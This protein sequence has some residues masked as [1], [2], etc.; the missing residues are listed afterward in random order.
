MATDMT[1]TFRPCE[2]HLA[3]TPA[4]FPSGHQDA[5]LVEI[6]S[7]SPRGSESLAYTVVPRTSARVPH[8]SG[9]GPHSEQSQQ[10]RGNSR[11]W[12]RLGC[13]TTRANDAQC[14]GQFI[15]TTPLIHFFRN[16]RHILLHS[17]NSLRG[18]SCTSAHGHFYH[19]LSASYIS[20]DFGKQSASRQSNKSRSDSLTLSFVGFGCS[21][22]PTVH[23]TGMT[24]SRT[25]HCTTAICN[26]M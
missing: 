12:G 18:H 17:G 21:G 20:D 14:S 2:P 3:E 26:D 15:P 6:P 13:C 22:K 1:C 8:S 7:I 11:P 10:Q 16:G 25:L 23:M 4:M 24:C 19:V 9:G 5:G